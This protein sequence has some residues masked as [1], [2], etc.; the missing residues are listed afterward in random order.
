MHRFPHPV[1]VA[2]GLR[3][4]FGR[5]GGALA[6]YDAISLSV[7]VVQTMAAH[8]EPDL[9]VWGS[10]IPNL[11]WSNIAR[12]IWLDA[13]LNPNV[14]AFSVVL[15]CSTSMTASFAAAG[16]LSDANMMN[17][18]AEGRYGYALFEQ[19]AGA[20]LE[21][22]QEKP[23]LEGLSTD[24]F[25]KVDAYLSP[26]Q[27]HSHP[28]IA[29][30]SKDPDVLGQWRA[31]GQNG[32]GWAIGFDGAALAV[33][34]VTL[35]D[36]VYDPDQQLAEIRNFLVAMYMTWRTLGGAF[37]E[38][39]GRD[40]ALLSSL[41]LA[42]K[43]PSFREEQ[44]VRALHE[45]RVDIAEDGWLLVDEGGSSEEAEAAGLPVRFRAVDSSVTANVDIA[46]PALEKGAIRELWFGPRNVN[47][48]GNAI[49]PL[50]QYGH[51][52]VVLHRSTSSYRG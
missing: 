26:K 15:A 27:L 24:F 3:T 47:G 37:E 9:V 19:A 4:P 1:F 38:A 46:L 28:V 44:E 17:D 32:E 13:K 40:A 21:M 22:A 5:G 31:Y 29:C 42:Y 6:N 48:S 39:V 52:G 16:M 25:D 12:E 33:M 18:A 35:L 14:P 8:A 11:G 10:V 20:L 30:F 51:R 45:L 36:V 41:L 34:P 2:A 49:Y 43:H 7:P 50:T 23:Q